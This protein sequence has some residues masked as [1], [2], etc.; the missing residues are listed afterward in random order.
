MKQW[1]MF[2][3]GLSY[4]TVAGCAVKSQRIR[5]ALVVWEFEALT[6]NCSVPGSGLLPRSRTFVACHSTSVSPLIS[7]HLSSL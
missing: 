7:C 2:C 1:L 3:V 4:A 5:T 6:M